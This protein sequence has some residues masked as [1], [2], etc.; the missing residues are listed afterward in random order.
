[1]TEEPGRLHAPGV[2]KSRT[3]WKRLSTQGEGDLMS[4]QSYGWNSKDL[5]LGVRRN[6]GDLF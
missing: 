4:N 2:V 6:Q 5:T 3:R 1:M